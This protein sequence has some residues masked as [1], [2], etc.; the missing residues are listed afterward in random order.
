MVLCLLL[1]ALDFGEVVLRLWVDSWG[2]GA[3]LKVSVVLAKRFELR[4]LSHDL[5]FGGLGLL[6]LLLHELL[7]KL[8]VL[9]F[10]LLLEALDFS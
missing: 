7:L 6:A 1:E 9:L 5:S 3:L 2:L 8:L 4:L 10:G